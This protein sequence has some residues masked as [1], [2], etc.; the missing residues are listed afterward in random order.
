MATLHDLL[1]SRGGS[2]L[3]RTHQERV[4]LIQA[5]RRRRTVPHRRLSKLSPD[6]QK[7]LLA[8]LLATQREE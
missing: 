6:Q 7:E 2:F 1:R 8:W 5:V 3:E 4:A